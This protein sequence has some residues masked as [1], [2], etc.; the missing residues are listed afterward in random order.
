MRWP[1]LVAALVGFLSGVLI[2]I[3]WMLAIDAVLLA[4]AC[5]LHGYI[6]GRRARVTCATQ[7]VT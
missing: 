3:S 4:I 7:E 2:P 5:Y 6:D 1:Y